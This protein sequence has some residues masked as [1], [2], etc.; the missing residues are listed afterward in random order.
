MASTITISF[1]ELDAYRQCPKKHEYAYKE[2]WQAPTTGPALARGTLWHQV[3]ESHYRFL[4]AWQQAGKP[5]AMPIFGNDNVLEPTE[6]ALHSQAMVHLYHP[7][8]GKPLSPHS[9]LI[10]WMYAGHVEHYGL[11]NE[12]KI[13]AVEHAPVMWLP[14]PNG[15]RSRFRLKMKIDLVVRWDGRLWIV[16]HKSG[17]DLP[18]DKELDLDDQFGLYTWGM[19]KLGKK[20]F[21]SVHSSARTQKNKDQSKHPQPLPERF[22]RKRLYRTDIE[23]DNIAVDAY[24]SARRAWTTKLGEAERQTNPDTCR[25]RCDFTEPCLLSRKGGDD[26]DMLRSIGFI[27]NFERH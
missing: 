5:R 7:K 8:S 13:M 9:E 24:K 17:K 15:G 19:R 23:L 4:M 6:V 12:W 20:V 2:R 22:A 21:G 11:D 25:W 14:T 27:Q 18:K 10:E 16:D 3:L 1:S 26:R